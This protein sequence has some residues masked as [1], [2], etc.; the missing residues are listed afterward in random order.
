MREYL[1][2]VPHSPEECAIDPVDPVASG[3]PLRSYRGCGSGTHTSWI[4]AELETE[5]E[6]WSLVP[7]LLRDTARVVAVERSEGRA[8]RFVPESTDRKESEER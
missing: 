5:D 4:I 2:E 3:A 1:I 8:A 7:E 6:A